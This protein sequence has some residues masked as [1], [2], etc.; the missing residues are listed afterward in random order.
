MTLGRNHLIEATC[1]I[2]L[3]LGVIDKVEE[4]IVRAWL[5]EISFLY[6][7]PRK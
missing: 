5:T 3:Q 4:Q 7:P 2:I 1:K 6:R